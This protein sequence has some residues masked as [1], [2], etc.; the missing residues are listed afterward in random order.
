MAKKANQHYV[1][2]FY[3]RFFSQDGKRICVLNRKTGNSIEHAPI[4]GQASKNYFYGEESIENA[5]SEIEGHFSVVLQELRKSVSFTNYSY[6]NLILFLQNLMLQKSRTISARQKSKPAID[7]LIQLHLEVAINNDEEISDAEKKVLR[8]SL[9]YIS[10]ESKQHQLVEMTIALECAE[11]LTDLLPVILLNKTNRPFIF[12]D[13]PVVFYNQHLKNITLRGV[14]GTQTPGLIIY[15]PLDPNI[16]VLLI[17]RSRYEIKGLRDSVIT[18]RRLGDIESLNKLQIHNAANAI[19]FSDYKYSKYVHELWR[20]EFKK[21]IN[22]K[23]NVVEAPGFNEH[24]ES[25][26]DIL[27]IYEEQLPF[28]PKLSFLSCNEITEDEYQFSPRF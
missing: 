18:L 13:A 25:I 5:L 16:S 19:F 10:A 27:H 17:D 21:F 9:P 11:H 26:G 24:E 15:Y 2:K 20:Q 4:K 3:F 8:E 6:Q 14:L 7:R 28:I 22:H 23:A 1:P 12:S